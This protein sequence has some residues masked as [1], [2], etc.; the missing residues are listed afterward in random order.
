METWESKRFISKDKNTGG[1]SHLLNETN[2]IKVFTVNRTTLY[3]KTYYPINNVINKQFHTI[4]HNIFKWGAAVRTT[5]QQQK[6][7]KMA[8]IFP[9]DA[10]WATINQNVRWK[11]PKCY[12]RWM[13]IFRRIKYSNRLFGTKNPTHRDLPEQ[14]RIFRCGTTV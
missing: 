14:K 5:K 8:S 1:L 13:M 7:Q 11:S 2:K 10:S 4:F 9:K 12:A 6:Q 3:P